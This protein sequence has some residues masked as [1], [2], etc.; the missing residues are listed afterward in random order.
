MTAPSIS[1]NHNTARLLGSLAHLA[2]GPARARILLLDGARP[3][4][5]G[6]LTNTLAIIELTDPPG[7]IV[8]GWLELYPELPF[9][10]A[11]GTGL[12]TWAR[13]LAGDGDWN[14][15]CDVSDTSGTAPV[16]LDDAN[17]TAGG[18]VTLISA[19]FR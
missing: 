11:L 6:A 17:V 19:I 10:V 14:T 15:D 4:A 9:V 2:A 13:F 1:P 7:A 16:Q 5:G 3:A 18:K 8:T 12:V